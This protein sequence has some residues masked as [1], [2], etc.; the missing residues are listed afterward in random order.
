[1]SDGPTNL[2]TQVEVAERL[3]KTV[4]T[5]A[6]LRAQGQLAYLP[7][8]PVLIAEDELERYLRREIQRKQAQAEARARAARVQPLSPRQRARKMVAEMIARG[9]TLPTLRRP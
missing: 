7:G 1:M 4:K 6:R 2:L 9:E 8:R 5:V 3:R